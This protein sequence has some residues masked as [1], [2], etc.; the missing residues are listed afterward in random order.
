MNVL[1]HCAEH[2]FPSPS[3]PPHPNKLE[4]VG[5]LEDAPKGI[6]AVGLAAGIE[7]PVKYDFGE[8]AFRCTLLG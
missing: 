7:L 1:R 8:R 6:Y 4:N 5:M 3:L 2:Q